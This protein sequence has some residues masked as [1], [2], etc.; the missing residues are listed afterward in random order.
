MEKST[1]AVGEGTYRDEGIVLPVKRFILLAEP[2]T[3][4]RRHDLYLFRDQ[5]VVFYVG[6]SHNA[7]ERV[8]AHL[9][10][11]FQGHSIVGR[12]I[13]NNW[14]RSMRF[15]VQLMCSASTL[16]EGVGNDL[17]GAER[18]LIEAYAP[19]F[20]SALNAQPTPLPT[21]YAAPNAR[22]RRPKSLRQMIH[23]AE[24]A[25]QRERSQRPWE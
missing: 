21:R 1:S 17:N 15:S 10:G 11:G 20:N 7:F 9:L 13:L 2:P 4:W 24:R 6:Q 12:F 5:E 18:Q 14:P 23:D 22:V 25:L 8:W 16:F 3:T 19:C